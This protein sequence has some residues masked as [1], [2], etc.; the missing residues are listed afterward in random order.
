MV[1]ANPTL[2]RPLLC[3]AALVWLALAACSTHA[4]RPLTVDDAAT[5]AKGEGHVEAWYA[6]MPGRAHSWNLAPA[7]AP[8]EGL[9]FSG[10]VARDTTNRVNMQALQVKW[11]VTPPQER[12]CNAGLVGGAGR[13]AAAGN[14][15]STTPY[16]NGLLTCRQGDWAGHA[17][18]GRQLPDGAPAATTWGLAVERALGAVTA[19]AEAF[20]ERHG[21]PT[22]QLGL[23]T[24]LRPGLQLDGTV[25][26]AESQTVFS[27]GLKQSF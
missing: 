10:L 3:R 7:Y 25:G 16:F 15:S 23:R 27:V 18:L 11:I 22:R 14:A 5:N 2:L 24:E 26:R 19:H 12:G 9:E 17:N 1:F 13:S 8:I 4:G 21:R 6:R 20:G